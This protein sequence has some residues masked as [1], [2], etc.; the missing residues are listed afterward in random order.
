MAEE[1]KV[2]INLRHLMDFGKGNFKI[3]ILN[4]GRIVKNMEELV[5]A[6]GDYV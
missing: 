6:A 2:V 4:N 1:R 5:L 3:K